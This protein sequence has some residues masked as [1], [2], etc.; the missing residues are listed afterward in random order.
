M[1]RGLDPNHLLMQQQMMR[2]IGLERAKKTVP[3]R[4]KDIK[5]VFITLRIILLICGVLLVIPILFQ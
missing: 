1:G 5:Y 4:K 3:D 2:H